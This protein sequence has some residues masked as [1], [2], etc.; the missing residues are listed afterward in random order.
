MAPVVTETRLYFANPRLK[1]HDEKYSL[2]ALS[3]IKNG[4]P[5]HVAATISQKLIQIT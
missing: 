1:K 4:L 2:K 5:S 3:M